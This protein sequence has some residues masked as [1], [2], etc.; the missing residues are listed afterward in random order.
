MLLTSESLGRLQLA[1]N[2]RIFMTNQFHGAELVVGSG[3][4]NNYC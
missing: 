1:P 4:V 2:Q 3:M